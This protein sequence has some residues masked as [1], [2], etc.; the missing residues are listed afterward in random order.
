MPSPASSPQSSTRSHAQARHA[1]PHHIA[2]TTPHTHAAQSL[3]MG[4]LFSKPKP[5]D[6]NSPPTTDKKP[7]TDKKMAT[8]KR[9][10][11]ICIDGWGVRTESHGNA[12][13]QAATPVMDGFRDGSEA[14]WGVVAAHGLAVGLPDGVM[15]NSEVGHL[16]I[17]AGQVEYQDLVR[18]NLCVSEGK[19]P[20]V[21]NLVAA[22]ESA[23]KGSGKLHLFGLLSDGGVHSHI[24]HLFAIL[25]AAKAAGVPRVL[26]HMCLDG[27]DVGPTTGPTY[28]AQ[29]EKKLADLGLGEI[30]TL[31]GRYYAMDRDKRWERV[32]LAYDVMCRADGQCERPEGTLADLLTAKHAAGETDEFVKPVGVLADGGIADGDTFLCY[33]YRS[34]RAREMFEAI[35]TEPAFETAVKR[36]PAQCFS[37][38]Q[39]SSAFTSPQVFPPQKLKNGLSEWISEQ[40]LTQ[41][42]VAETEKYAHVT[43]F[44]N[45]APLL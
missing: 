33:N 42:H 32:Q 18:I 13:L 30:S 8:V 31:S 45:G 3:C 26:L 22:F 35:S 4:G 6:P 44:F 19:L 11:L 1:T 21:P 25:D 17:G 37:F 7:S 16:T 12:I 10:A 2:D 27:R 40:G 36:T 5:V 24:D 20:S 34:D 9:A 29:L 28:V 14:N 23:K 15:G 43:F 41:Y 39:Y 38:T